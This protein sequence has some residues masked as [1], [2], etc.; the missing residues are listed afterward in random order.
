[1]RLQF[2][3][4]SINP[5]AIHTWSYIEN[6]DGK[7]DASLT[8]G[9]FTVSGHLKTNCEFCPELTDSLTEKWDDTDTNR[10]SMT[11]SR[12]ELALAIVLIWAIMLVRQRLHDSHDS[13]SSYSGDSGGAIYI[14][15]GSSGSRS[16]LQT[17]KSPANPTP[18]PAI[19]MAVMG[20]RRR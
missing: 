5:A 10:R 13:N 14:G 2:R 9:R 7:T 18:T 12:M 11:A 16:Y 19:P 20:R 8:S 1:M 6:C 17:M 4:P 3:D 15:D